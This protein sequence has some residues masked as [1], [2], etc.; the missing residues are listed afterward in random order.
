MTKCINTG[1]A[2]AKL[3]ND[4]R[5]VKRL[6]QILGATLFLGFVIQRLFVPRSARI[7][8]SDRGHLTVYLN[9]HLAGSMVAI[10]LLMAL[11]KPMRRSNPR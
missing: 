11:E 1:A 9:D 6:G 5:I 10:E 8:K 2:G 3:Q 7:L 4:H